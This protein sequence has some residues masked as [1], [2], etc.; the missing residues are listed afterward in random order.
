MWRL[1]SGLNRARP[2]GEHLEALW[3]MVKAQVAYLRGL[4]ARYNV[5]VFCGY[6]SNCDD[7]GVEIPHTS[8]EIFR[9]LEISFGLSIIIT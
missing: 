1:D 3:G 5:D 8:L 6:R 2:L 4:K 7:A 9:E